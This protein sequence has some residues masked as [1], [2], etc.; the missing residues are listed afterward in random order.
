MTQ[1]FR[2]LILLPLLTL[3]ACLPLTEASNVTPIVVNQAHLTQHWIR[4]LEE[5]SQG[6]E[7]Q[8][9]RHIDDQKGFKP[10]RFRMQR[11][12][13]ENGEYEWLYL[14]P[15]D[16]H[17]LK[18]GSWHLDAKKPVLRL[19][20]DNTTQHYR[21]IALTEKVLHLEPVKP[22]HLPLAT[23][24]S[25]LWHWT[26]SNT[27]SIFSLTLEKIDQKKYTVSYCA[28]ALSGNKIDCSSEE[29]NTSSMSLA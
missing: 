9:Y 17:Y 5:E 23:D 10:T 14:A 27:K 22:S 18:S 13:K 15:N 24:L 2:L 3:S 7:V 6:S 25:G 16:A 28:V 8:I 11:V 4:S 19:K 29:K 1:L 26:S 21:I 20:E 12:F